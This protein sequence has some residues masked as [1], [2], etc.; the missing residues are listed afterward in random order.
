VFAIDDF[1]SA[2]LG[3]IAGGFQ[4]VIHHLK[5][6]RHILAF[7]PY[8]SLA[9]DEISSSGTSPF[10]PPIARAQRNHQLLSLSGF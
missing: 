2:L 3:Q 6:Y 9:K 8:F 10:I 7:L 5:A 1:E 4:R